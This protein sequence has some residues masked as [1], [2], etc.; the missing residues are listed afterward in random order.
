MKTIEFWKMNGSGNDFILIDNRDG[1]VGEDEMGLLVKRTCD[2][3]PLRNLEHL[4]IRR[5]GRPLEDDAHLCPD[6]HC[7]GRGP[8]DVAGDQDAG[9]G[10]GL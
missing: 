9:H 10:A 2:D 1:S 7:V 8:R 3:L 6:F 4:A 5:I